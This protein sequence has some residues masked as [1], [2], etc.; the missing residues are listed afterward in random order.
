MLG[1]VLF[2]LPC[3]NLRPPDLAGEITEVISHPLAPDQ[4]VAPYHRILGESAA[5]HL[6]KIVGTIHGE[7]G[8]I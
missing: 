8:T 1:D 4:T 3:P 7:A 2:F 5:Y 6:R